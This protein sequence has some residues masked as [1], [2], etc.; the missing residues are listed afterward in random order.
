[1]KTPRPILTI[2]GTRGTGMAVL[3]TLSVA[4]ADGNW[5]QF[6]GPNSQG[7]QEEAKPP[8][9]LDGARAVLW[10]TPSPTGVS[11]PC[12]WGERIFL[13]GFDGARQQLETLCLDA[14]SGRILWRKDAPAQEVEKVHEASS[15]ANTSPLTDGV[16]VYVHFPMFGLVAYTLDGDMAWTKPLPPSKMFFGC[17]SSPAFVEGTLILRVATAKEPHIL[18]LRCED[19]QS[20][21]KS[22]N[23]SFGWGWATP[24]TWREGGRTVIGVRSMGRFHVLDAGTGTNVWKLSGIPPSSCATPAVSDERIYISGV[25]VFGNRESLANPP[26]FDEVLA[27][28]D[29]DHDGRIAVGELPESLL[30]LDRGVSSGLGSRTWKEELSDGRDG[31]K[32]SFNRTEWTAATTGILNKYKT[33]GTMKTATLAVRTGGQGDATNNLVWSEVKGVPEVPSPLLYRGRLYYIKNGGI[34]TSRDPQ[35]GRALY[36][37]RIGAD[38]GYFASPVAADGRIYVASDRGVVSVVQAGD[39]F[40]VLSRVDLREAIQATPALAGNKLYVRTAH[41]FWALG[42]ESSP[43]PNP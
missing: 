6:R 16:R 14:T 18:A 24:V 22:V 13:T 3:C 12:V 35:T 32:K 15:P 42:S 38:G 34:M 28:Y 20:V 40:K 10:K 1:M 43:R 36:E 4:C 37:E 33:G 25:G 8:A 17:G 29:A 27:R 9:R 39:E 5:P 7:V 19:G 2:G 41:H 11:S 23:S 30:L 31:A 26:D 21:W